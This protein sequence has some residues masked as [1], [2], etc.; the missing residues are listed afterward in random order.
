MRKNVAKVM[1]AWLEGRKLDEGSVSTDGKSIFSYATCILTRRSDLRVI[2]NQ[3]KYSVTTSRQQGQIGY[4]LG[5]AYDD[6]IR[7]DDLPRGAK[8]EDLLNAAAAL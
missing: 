5:R 3:T 1:I 6:I 7:V 8:A 2:L 4:Q